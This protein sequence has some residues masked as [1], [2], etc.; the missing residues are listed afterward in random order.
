M[1]DLVF[2]CDDLFLAGT[3]P[4]VSLSVVAIILN[5]Q[6]HRELSD[7]KCSNNLRFVSKTN[8]VQH[9][10]CSSTCDLDYK[11]IDGFLCVTYNRLLPDTSLQVKPK[12]TTVCSDCFSKHL[13]VVCNKKA[14]YLKNKI[15]SGFLRD[16]KLNS[17]QDC[18]AIKSTCS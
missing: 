3:N 6:F 9:F 7:Q 14:G 18:N 12:H 10:S 16:S 15:L 2:C 4:F 5:C 13:R 8:C 11:D 1:L 17:R